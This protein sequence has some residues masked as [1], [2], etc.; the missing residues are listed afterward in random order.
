VILFAMLVA[1]TIIAGRAASAQAATYTVGTLEDFTGT[2]QEPAAGG[3]SLR[4]LIAYEDTLADLGETP[5]PPDTIVVPAPEGTASYFL[6]NGVLTITQSVSI[7]GAG[8]RK[9]NLD[10]FSETPNRVFFIEPNPR[11]KAVPTVAISGLSIAFGHANV[12]NGF[13]GGDILNEGTLTLSEDAITNGTTEAGSGGGISNDGGTLTVTHSLV[14]NNISIHTETEGGG[15]SGGIQNLGP[16]PVTKEAGRLTVEDSTIANNE[17]AL[18]GGIFSWGDTSNTTSIVNSTI[19]NNKGGTRGVEGGGIE[20]GGLLATEG[21]ITVANSIVALNTVTEPLTGLPT[22]SDCGASGIFS[23]G[24]NLESGT[25]CGFTAPGD[26]QNTDPQFMASGLQ[27]NGGNTDTLALQA[28]SPA[29]DAIPSNAPGCGASDQRDVARPQGTGCDIGAYE[30]FQPVEGRQFSEVVGVAAAHEGTTPRIDWGDKTQP[31]LGTVDPNTDQLTGAHTY[32]EEGT[33]HA[34][35]TFVNSDGSSEI[36]LFDVKVQDAPLTATG[37]PVSA[38]A[39]VQFNATVATFSDADPGGVALDYTATISWGD[40]TTSA[41]SVGPVAGGGFAVTGSHTYAAGGVYQVNVTISDVGGATATATSSANVAPPS[42]P[43]L[44]TA[45]P[46]TVLTTTSAAFTTTVNPHGLPTTVHFEYGPVLG[47]AK[48]AAITYGSVTPDQSVGSDF[49]DHTVTATVTGLLPNV[50]YHVRAVATNSAGKTLGADQAL[51][52]PADPPPP[53]PVLGKSANVAPVSGIVYIELPPGA[54]FASLSPFDLVARA[55][56][57]LTKGRRFVPLTEARQIPVGSILDTTAGVANITTATT[58]SRKGKLQSGDF[59]AGIFKL[60][61]RRHQRGL[62]ELN[63][64]NNHSA[65]QVCA[66]H[67]KARIAAKH[68]SSK[69]LGRLTANSHGR[70]TAHGQYS[71]ATVRGTIWSVANRCDG[72]LTHVKRGVLAVRDFHRRKTITLFTG[73]TYLARAHP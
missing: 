11:T 9:V 36:R 44:L 34:S 14:S 40:G 30:L 50:T 29:V 24:H 62:T 68:P 35:F 3:C 47:G 32:A 12:K 59:G 53:P 69:V 39:G 13:F 5:N 16:N 28:T 38:G 25:D 41:G 27:D 63:I 26:L 45:S 21:T 37:V 2:C 19:A 17:A 57:A 8:T 42:A 23:L 58:A 43:T 72:T 22:P 10:Q 33:Y 64:I 65:R 1:L 46:P 52:T 4:Q 60:L 56:A 7:V 54:K 51:N 61:Q 20:G 18:G 67:G 70:F 31:S 66:T 73:Q 48:A 71:A 55:F 49:S 15:D 6:K